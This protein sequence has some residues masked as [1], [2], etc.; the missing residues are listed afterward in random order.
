MG[1]VCNL[2]D[3]FF[4]TE[5]WLLSSLQYVTCM[6]YFGTFIIHSYFIHSKIGRERLYKPNSFGTDLV[7]VEV[8]LAP[9]I[10]MKFLPKLAQLVESSHVK[11][12]YSESMF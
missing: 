1:F 4:V 12:Y 5:Y 2:G 6:I 11:P 10:I 8:Y 9:I 7:F 3:T